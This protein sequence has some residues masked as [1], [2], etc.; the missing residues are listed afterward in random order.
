MEECLTLNPILAD[1]RLGRF[2][3][4]IVNQGMGQFATHARMI[5]GIDHDDPV[6]IEQ[7]LGIGDKRLQID[8]GLETQIRAT[9]AKDLAAHFI[10]DH[11]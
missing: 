9:I 4:H 2:R 5:L 11:Q 10:G 1:Q 7:L 6:G 8:L 3:H